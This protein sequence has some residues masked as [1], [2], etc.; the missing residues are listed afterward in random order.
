MSDISQE[1]TI[2][3]LSGEGSRKLLQQV[4]NSMSVELSSAPES[5]SA[6]RGRNIV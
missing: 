5:M 6:C 1:T 2:K 3:R 4:A